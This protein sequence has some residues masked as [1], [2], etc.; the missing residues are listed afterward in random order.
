M[1]KAVTG[2]TRVAPAHPCNTILI[3]DGQPDKLAVVA[4]RLTAL[5]YRPVP[6]RDGAEALARVDAVQPDLILL[7]AALADMDGL[8]VCR[9]LKARAGTAQI[10]VIFM[11]GRQDA[12]SQRQALALGAVDCVRKPLRMDELAARVGAQLQLRLLRRGVH[13]AV[14]ARTAELRESNRRLQFELAERRAAELALAASTLGYQE[15]FDY[16]ADALYLIEG[17]EDG[18][19]RYVQVNPAFARLAGMPAAGIPGQRVSQLFGAAAGARWQAACQRCAERGETVDEELPLELGAGRCILHVTMVR[20]S[21]PGRAG[22]RLAGI[23]R[24]VTRL[25]D[26]QA[27]LNFLARRDPLTALPNRLSFRDR[28]S[29]ALAGAEAHGGE[30]AVLLLGLDHFRDLNDGLGRALG[31]RLLVRC[32]AAL[33]QAV[34][35]ADAVARIGGDEFAIVV[36]GGGDAAARLARGLLRQLARPVE[37]DDYELA[38]A[39]SIGIAQWP[40]D[41]RDADT[42]L[43]NADAAMCRAKA[44]GGGRH[45]LFTTE[46][47]SSTRRRVEIGN[48]LRY[49]IRQGELSLHY[50]PRAGLVDGAAA[51]MEAL[52]RWHSKGRGAVG[53]AEFIP[54]AEQNGLILQIG[55]WVLRQACQQAEHWRRRFGHALPVAVNLSARQFRDADLVRVVETALA[56]SGLPPGLLELELTESMLMHDARRTQRTLAALKSLGVR[57]AVDDFGTGYSSLSY[58]KSFPLDYLKIDRAFVAGLPDDRNDGAIVRAIIAMAHTLGLKVIA[59]G[60]ETAGQLDFLRTQRCDEVQGFFYSRPLAVA[61]MTTYLSLRGRP[62]WPPADAAEAGAGETSQLSG[63]MYMA[64]LRRSRGA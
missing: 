3:V 32:A 6:V 52:L 4:D 9:Q 13:E 1:R 45:Q 35:D 26:Y 54:L 43:G 8:E 34:G 56:A 33:D 51:G 42:L 60:V 57:L 53:P 44:E 37:I 25:H 55:A 23:G 24:D 10:P 63:S 11:A 21:V 19:F 2:G 30:V 17:G 22:C 31:D 18:Q 5:G 20:S 14:E 12:A 39:C 62:A 46:M 15:I 64:T 40:R 27:Q 47:N 48:A 58:L 7:G 49:A 29:L 28:L 36:E 59:E 16:A 61:E 41:G 38:L 50:Q